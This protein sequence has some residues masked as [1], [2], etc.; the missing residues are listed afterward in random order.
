MTSLRMDEIL[1]ESII[2]KLQGVG[3]VNSGW[4]GR[5]NEINTEKGDDIYIAAPDVGAYYE[6]RM[7]ELPATPACFVLAGQG[8]YRE[9]GNHSLL[10]SY[11]IYVHIVDSD[12]NGPRLA[13]RLMRQARAVLEVLYDDT[14]MEQT[15]VQGAVGSVAAYRIFPKSSIPGAVFEPSGEGW[16]GTYVFVFRAEQEEN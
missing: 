9:Q 15:Y 13:R 14:P 8:S 1:V 16:R 6:G 11:D 5:A 4:P 7:N 12:V 10:T 3:G 2:A